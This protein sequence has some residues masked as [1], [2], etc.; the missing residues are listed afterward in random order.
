MTFVDLYKKSG[1]KVSYPTFKNT[2]LNTEKL[3]SFYIITKNGKKQER[4][5]YLIL[6]EK[7]IIDFFK[8]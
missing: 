8:A 3:K 1:L 7:P 4:K 6:D 2:I 5:T